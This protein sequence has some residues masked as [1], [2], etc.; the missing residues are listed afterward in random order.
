MTPLATLEAWHALRQSRDLAHRFP[1]FRT[2]SPSDEGPLSERVADVVRPDRMRELV[3]AARNGGARGPL[4][5]A[6]PAW[7]RLA[8]ARLDD[9][10]RARC[11]EALSPWAGDVDA[12]LA[13]EDDPAERSA[14]AVRHARQWDRLRA[15]REELA[16]ARDAAAREVGAEDL[17]ALR[18]LGCEPG[19]EARVGAYER[20]F[21]EPLD[22]AIG[23]AVRERRRRDGDDPS[24]PMRAEDVPAMAWLAPWRRRLAAPAIATV[25]RRLGGTIGP[26]SG[27]DGALLE[28]VATPPPRAEAFERVRPRPVVVLGSWGGPLGLARTLDAF[29]RAQRAA[30]CAR[31]WASEA[32]ASGD[33]AFDVAA[34]VLLRRLGTS[35]TC[36][37]EAGIRPEADMLQALRLEEAI[38]PRAAWARAAGNERRASGR[39]ET[40]G[41]GAWRFRREGDDSDAVLRGTTYAV[42]VE[43]RVMTRWGRGWFFDRRAGAYLRDLWAGEAGESPESMAEAC[44]LGTMDPSPLLERYRP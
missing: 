35:Q 24:A 12:F 30:F 34:G 11:D 1:G 4:R 43:E 33:P 3:E 32:S 27:D 41:A 15:A 19:A 20:G 38:A 25:L 29:G 44:G 36:L 9:E 26:V 42:L 21:M 6:T 40:P 17:L 13:A 7:I 14:I 31:A 39:P 16:G 8:T 22:G 18:V 28:A 5:L 10:V 37:A 2:V 23:E